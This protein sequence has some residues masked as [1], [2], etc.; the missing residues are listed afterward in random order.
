M[1]LLMGF[2]YFA[3]DAVAILLLVAIWQRSRITGFLFLA[4]GHALG[5]LVRWAMPWVH[6]LVD[7][8]GAGYVMG[9]YSVVWLV[10]SAVGLYGL[11]DIY[12][13]YKRGQPA[14]LPAA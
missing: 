4:A 5:I 11:W 3:L 8:D 1:D 6:R 7:G 12:R 13:H 14:A 2:A 9:L 10:V